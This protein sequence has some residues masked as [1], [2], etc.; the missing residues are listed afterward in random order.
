MSQ[1]ISKKEKKMIRTV[2]AAILA[3]LFLLA[4]LMPFV[5]S[6]SGSELTGDGIVVAVIDTGF[7]ADYVGAPDKLAEGRYYFFCEEEDGRYAITNDG[8][9]KQYGYYSNDS[10]EDEKGH[11]TMVASVIA[12]IAPNVTIMPVKCFTAQPG[13]V[14]GKN[15]NFISGI[16]YAVD[17]GAD[18][19]N[20]SWGTYSDQS[21]ALREAIEEAADAGCILIA[22]AG[23]GGSVVPHYPSAYPN[24]ISV[25]ATN[26]QG[27]IAIFSQRG[28]WVDIYARGTDIYFVG[29]SP[30]SKGLSGTSYSTAVVSGAAA[31]ALEADPDM[32]Q[33]ELLGLLKTSGDPI[34]GQVGAEALNLDELVKNAKISR[35]Q[36]QAA[37]FFRRNK[38]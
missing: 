22:S 9:T 8:V 18:I 4:V 5:A 6:A 33:E 38:S 23:N 35:L 15:P 7:N 27:E 10:I 36:D 12:D 28:D 30:Q 3:G 25:G 1:K 14:S 24:V 31:L 11:G 26:K 21:P 17:N 20:M 29:T 19:I 16:R 34:D 2:I 13:H 37:K 32:T